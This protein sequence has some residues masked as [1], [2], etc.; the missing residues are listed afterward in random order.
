MPW[1]PLPSSEAGDTTAPVAQ[2]LDRVLRSM[3]APRASTVRS[4]F[5]RWSEIV[6]E[7]VAAHATPV[8]LRD[9]HLLVDVADPA[10]ATQLRFLDAEILGR[11]AGVLGPGEVTAVEVRVRRGGPTGRAR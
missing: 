9:G 6:G 7:Q 2:P 11:A 3:R 8:S 5:D 1:E 10:W 4:V